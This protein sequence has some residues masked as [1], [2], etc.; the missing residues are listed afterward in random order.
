MK[1]DPRRLA[2]LGIHAR[3]ARDTAQIYQRLRQRWPKTNRQPDFHGNRTA[4][5]KSILSAFSDQLAIRLSQG[6][7]A[8]RLVGSRRGKL[9][10]QSCAR[11]AE[12]FVACEITE[13]E[14]RETTTH[15]RLVT[16]VEIQ[17]LE[18]LFPGGHK[19]H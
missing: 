13:V 16:P 10:D 19:N 17:W 1:F 7:L 11:S 12:A 9:D 8:C 2:P 15:L 18:E 5:G 14:A 6:N 3:G 4:V